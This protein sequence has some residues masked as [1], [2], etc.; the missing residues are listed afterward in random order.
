MPL[1]EQPITTKIQGLIIMLDIQQK[2][3]VEILNT[4]PEDPGQLETALI[5]ITEC[6]NNLACYKIYIEGENNYTK[7]N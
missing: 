5:K 2:K 3:L 6:I 7:T 1:Q 4:K